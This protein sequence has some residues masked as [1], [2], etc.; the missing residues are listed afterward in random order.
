MPP[1]PRPKV[2]EDQLVGFKYFR[3]ILR[4]L[5]RLHDVGCTRDR[6]HNR[7]LHFDQY[8]ARILLYF[9]NPILT[10]LRAIQQASQLQKVQRKL[11]VPRASLGSLDITDGGGNEREQ[12][13]QTLLPDRVYVMDRGYASFALFD[14]IRAASS[15][16]VCRLRDDRV[17][18][19]IEELTAHI[20]RLP[21]IVQ[22]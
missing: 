10:S 17:Y 16:F 18:E 3:K 19:V 5:D 14:A 9:F 22:P 6:A 21:S 4:M 13:K 20:D 11:G 12:L 7:Q 1:R 8:T 2:T 15:S